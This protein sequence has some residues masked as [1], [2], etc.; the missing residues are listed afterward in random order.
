LTA[1]V[2][3]AV[4]LAPPLSLAAVDPAAF[5]ARPGGDP[6]AN[7]RALQ[8]A[9]DAAGS[10]GGGTVAVTA[11]GVYDLAAQG[12][13]P[14]HKGHRYC[15]ELRFDGQTLRL[16]AGVTLRLADGQQADDTGP[17]DVVIWGARR[18]LRITGPGTITG[19]TA[20]QRG[21]SHG[22]GQISKGILIAGYWTDRGRNDGIRIDGLTL[23]DHF[24]NAIYLNGHPDNRDRRIRI[25]GVTA[26]DTGEG[27]LVV[28]ADHVTLADNTYENASV[29]RHPGDGFE[30]WNVTRFRVRRTTVRGRLAGS[31]ID[32]Y[33]ARDGIVDGFTIEGG[34]E[35]VAV[36]ENISI[37]T[38]SE[39]VEVRNG[40]V[41]LAGAGSGVLTNGARVRHVRISNVEVGGGSLPGT[42]GFQV[43]SQNVPSRP[44]DDWR[45]QGPVTLKDCA[46]RDNDVGLLVKTVAGLTVEGGDY[47]GNDA[48]AASDGIRWIGQANAIRRHDTRGLVLRRVTATGNRRYGIHLDAEGRSGLA[49]TGSI[50]RCRL[51]GNG[52]GGLRVSSAPGDELARDLLLDDSCRGAVAAASAP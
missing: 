36:Q 35:G 7:T 22:Y 44:S 6:A 33:G 4:V 2:W 15:L 20:G 34:V 10:R 18:D 37:A 5:G 31:A 49:P 17:V 48:T 32:L 21:W 30:L 13:N 42:I 1:A 12:R 29:A 11:P 9:L 40:T 38:Y 45:Q 28:N 24:S 46:A 25:E 52:Q 19:N 3:A 41:T 8:A 23:A 14:Y 27:P 39:R 16:G 26:R 43:S 47:S 51:A 50:T